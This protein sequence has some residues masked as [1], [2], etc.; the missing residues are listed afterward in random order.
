M[1][2]IKNPYF[3]TVVFADAKFPAIYL[4]LYQNCPQPSLPHNLYRLSGFPDYLLLLG[5]FRLFLKLIKLIAKET[6]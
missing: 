2:I 3:D 1:T 4:Q 6:S 5:P